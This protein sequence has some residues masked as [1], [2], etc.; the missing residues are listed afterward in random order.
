MVVEER[1]EQ[2]S[3][4]ARDVVMGDEFFW[5]DGMNIV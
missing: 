5:K 2:L 4:E 1:S 3:K